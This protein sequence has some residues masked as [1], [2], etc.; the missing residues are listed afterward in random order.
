MFFELKNVNFNIF[1]FLWRRCFQRK[2]SG[3]YNLRSQIWWPSRCFQQKIIF[4]PRYKDFWLSSI[5]EISSMFLKHP[6]G[7]QIRMR[8]LKMVHFK[9]DN[10][11]ALLRATWPCLWWQEVPFG[12]TQKGSL[13]R[14]ITP[15]CGFW[16]GFIPSLRGA[17]TDIFW[18]L[19]L[20]SHLAR[21][22]TSTGYDTSMFWMVYHYTLQ[23]KK[24]PS[25][26][27]PITSSAQNRERPQ[28]QSPPKQNQQIRIPRTVPWQFR[29]S[30]E[31]QNSKKLPMAGHWSAKVQL[32]V[33]NVMELLLPPSAAM[34]TSTQI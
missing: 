27:T 1:I 32:V 7:L 19:Y 34:K 20:V 31:L 15:K 14:A 17:E 9:V 26:F 28:N 25:A 16:Q 10:T 23:R 4:W 18:N 33:A 12:T 6:R 8:C 22:R 2:N 21:Y 3:C 11:P 30:L 29:W 5:W 24:T 13:S